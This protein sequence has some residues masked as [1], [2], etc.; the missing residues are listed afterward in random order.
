MFGVYKGDAVVLRAERRDNDLEI[1]LRL[2]P[3]FLDTSPTIATAEYHET[4]QQKNLRI[5]VFDGRQ[6]HPVPHAAFMDRFNRFKRWVSLRRALRR[7]ARAAR[8]ARLRQEIIAA[9]WEPSRL[10]KGLIT[11]DTDGF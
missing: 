5:E 6:P 7:V 4:L 11:D 9:A 3:L 2:L 10:E 1:W 8:W